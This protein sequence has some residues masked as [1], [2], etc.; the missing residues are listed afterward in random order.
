M[1]LHR[2]FWM[3]CLVA[4]SAAGC[5]SPSPRFYTLSGTAAAAT[6]SPSIPSNLSIAVGPVSVPAQVDR[7]QMVL[8]KGA[9]QV[10]LDEL[11]RWAAPLVDNI[12]RVLQADLAQE[13]GTS[14]VWSQSQTMLATPDVQVVVDVQRFET[15]PGE[16][17]MI[18]VFW[19]VKRSAGGAAKTGRSL[20][21]EA[22]TAP[23]VEPAVAAHSRALARVSADIA[24]AI[25]AP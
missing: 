9:N 22:S 23:G 11:N 18:D 2:S 7:P 16:A 3:A 25:R 8:A 17:T 4:A 13:L 6:P 10:Q 15:A 24:A 14:N 12:S 21:H 20:V 1:L 19:T 5:A